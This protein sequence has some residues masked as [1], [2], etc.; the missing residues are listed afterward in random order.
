MNP[1]RKLSPMVAYLVFTLYVGAARADASPE[2]LAR[3]RSEFVPM[4]KGFREGTIDKKEMLTKVDEIMGKDWH[5][6]EP[7]STQIIRLVK[8][9][10]DERLG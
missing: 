2:Q 5:V 9:R 4:L 3:L 10:D 6:P 1:A 7:W 8:G